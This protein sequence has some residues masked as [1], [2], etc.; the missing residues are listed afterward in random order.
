MAMQ[1]P[2]LAAITKLVKRYGTQYRASRAL[3]IHHSM[4]PRWRTGEKYPSG[5]MVLR[6]QALAALD[7]VALAP[8]NLQMLL[9]YYG[10]LS[11]ICTVCV[12]VPN[13]LLE[14]ASHSRATPAEAARIDYA[15]RMITRSEHC[16]KPRLPASIG[17]AE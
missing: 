16:A 15:L 6:I 17:G 3:G 7:I 10:A 5:R 1:D 13:R 12:I 11:D 14:I 4:L 2:I 8:A 9:H